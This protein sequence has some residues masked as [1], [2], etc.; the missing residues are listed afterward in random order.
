MTGAAV[1]LGVARPAWAAQPAPGPQRLILPEPT[2]PYPVGTVSLYLVDA[3]R[4]D[5]AAG[6]GRHRELMAGVWYPAR[7]VRRY[8]RAPW[9]PA[10][11]LRALLTSAG[12]AADAALA[13]LT[14]GHEGAP[15]R[16]T[17]GRLPVVVFSHGAHDHRSDATV[18]VTVDHTDDAFSEFP[19]GRGRPPLDDPRRA[20]GP[21]D[22]AKD[23]RFV[24]DRVEE[25]GAGHN[26]D[27]EHPPLPVGLCGAL[28]PH[29][30]G[31]FGW[32]KGG[33]ATVVQADGAVHP[34][35]CDNQVLV[36]QLAKAI[37]MSDEGLW[38]T[39]ARLLTHA[40]ASG[41]GSHGPPR[42]TS[43]SSSEVET[44]SP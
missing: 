21:A 44:L 23:V 24:I 30:V 18:V 35:Y 19:D 31:M 29:R 14:A 34:S 43:P 17:G 4:P 26:P 40:G 27:A 28:D 16:R 32:S 8:P 9:M 5:P 39:R 42:A 2:G 1:P 11:P 25:L 41:G 7:D 10:A 33:T 3:S 13:P 22:F 38:S 6:P 12:F 15:G 37:G 36:P 20:L